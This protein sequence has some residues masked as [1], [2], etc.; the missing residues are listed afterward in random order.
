[1]MYPSEEV[2]KDI[3]D[4]L[5]IVETPFV[6]TL[7]EELTG[8]TKEN[9]FK[10]EEIIQNSLPYIFEFAFPIHDEQHR[11]ELEMKI[12]KHYFF[13]RICC[14]DI[15]EW[16]LRLADRL[17]E[18]MPYFNEMYQSKDYLKDPM[19]D[20][21]YERT[22]GEDTAK[23]GIENTKSTQNS[24][25]ESTGISVGQNDSTEHREDETITKYSD[26]PQGQL[27]GVLD[28]DYL[29]S[30][31]VVNNERDSTLKNTETRNDVNKNKSDTVG[32]FDTNSIDLGRRDM[33]EK[34]KGKMYG[35]SK[36]EMVLE[37]R[38]AI[39]NIDNE[40]ISRLSDLFLNIYMP[41]YGG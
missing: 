41:Y 37:Y 15:D 29:T 2:L 34:V 11:Q 9:G 10:Y 17:Q 14:T 30:A 21:D 22:V 31:N 4:Y 36:A 35:K 7:C 39:I 28:G 27:S 26:T 18:I 8:M 20:V 5:G 16:Q 24:E 3:N 33:T 38:K 19:D 32:T 40:I 25:G 1:M 12:I 13:R 6:K 23:N